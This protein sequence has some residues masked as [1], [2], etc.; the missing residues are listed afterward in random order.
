MA[1]QVSCNQDIAGQGAF[2]L[3]MIAEFA[4]SIEEEGPWFYRRLFWET[5]IV[6][7]ML[8]LES[9][10]RGVRGTGIGCYFDDAVHDILGLEDNTLQSLYHFTLGGAVEDK[11]LMTHPAYPWSC[12]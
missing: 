6:G 7:Q 4:P 12:D 2:S 3:G 5:G 8:Y 10:Y 1:S 9:E 11:R